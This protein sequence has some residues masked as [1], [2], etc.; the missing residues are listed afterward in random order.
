MRGEWNLQIMLIKKMFPQSRFAAEMVRVMMR[1]DN[2][3]TFEIALNKRINQIVQSVLF[4]FVGSR[5]VRT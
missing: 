2:S 3:L 4:G 1:R 5:R